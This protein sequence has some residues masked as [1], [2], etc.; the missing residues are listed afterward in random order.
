M[1]RSQSSDDKLS[2]EGGFSWT[3]P[4]RMRQLDY[5]MRLFSQ[6]STYHG[7]AFSGRVRQSFRSIAGVTLSP[8]CCL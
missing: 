5:R 7:R 8:S 3:L 2:L 1:I 6:M 4:Y